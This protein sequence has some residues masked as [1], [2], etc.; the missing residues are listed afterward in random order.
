M[1]TRNEKEQRIIVPQH[2]NIRKNPRNSQGKTTV[3]DEKPIYTHK[4][5]TLT[6]KLGHTM[7]I[8]STNGRSTISGLSG[9]GLGQIQS[10][11]GHLFQ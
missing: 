8:K 11:P 5:I 2:K 6:E 1:K 3:K 4:K 9:S 7:E 10:S